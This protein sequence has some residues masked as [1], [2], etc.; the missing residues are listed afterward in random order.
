MLILKKQ[1]RLIQRLAITNPQQRIFPDQG[2][3]GVECGALRINTC[4]R[5]AR[6]FCN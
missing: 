1:D 4:G 3:S 2:V 6:E 5:F